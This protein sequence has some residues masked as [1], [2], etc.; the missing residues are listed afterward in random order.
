[1]GA[2]LGGGLLVLVGLMIGFYIVYQSGHLGAALSTP[3]GALALVAGVTVVA[4][5][6]LGLKK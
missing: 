4:L 2:L 6:A 1:M 3:P 5:I